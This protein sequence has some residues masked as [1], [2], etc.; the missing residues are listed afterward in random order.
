MAPPGT[1]PRWRG[2]RPPVPDRAKGHGNTPALAGTTPHSATPFRAAVEHPRAGGDDCCTRPP[3]MDRRGTPPRWRGRLLHAAAANGQE[4]NTPALAGTTDHRLGWANHRREHPRAG[5]D[6]ANAA[7]TAI[8]ER[9]TPPRWRGRPTVPRY[10]AANT[11]NTPA[12]AGTTIAGAMSA[13]SVS[14]HPRAGGD[15]VI[16]YA[17]WAA[18]VG[19]PPR[20]RGR[21]RA[22]P[23]VTARSWNTPAL[24]GTTQ[25]KASR[26][27]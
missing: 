4:G 11:R 26:R 1:P 18:W 15:D 7:L 14:E 3:L 6:D 12:L 24:A 27:A 2:R 23:A 21:P 20:W 22:S 25:R 9:G 5:G 13:M 17:S 16:S 19:T 8:E 10:A